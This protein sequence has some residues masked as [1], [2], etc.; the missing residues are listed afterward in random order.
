[1]P[2]TGTSGFRNAAVTKVLVTVIGSCSTL[3]SL[4]ESHLLS[5]SKQPVL[6]SISSQWVFSSIGSTVVGTWLIYK[7]RVIE[8]RYGSSKFAALV[9]ISIIVSTFFQQIA[10]TAFP[11]Q[12]SINSP[13]ALIFA[14]L[15]QYHIIIPQTNQLPFLSMTINDKTYV[16]AAAIQLFAQHVPTSVLSCVCGLLT[17]MVYNNNIGNIQK[18]R[19]PQWIRSFSS[20]YLIPLLGTTSPLHHFSSS[21]GLSS[22]SSSS[23]SS[24]TQLNN[25]YSNNHSNPL[26]QRSVPTEVPPSNENIEALISMFPHCSRE[27]VANALTSSRHDLNRAAETLLTTAPPPSESTS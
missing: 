3:A 26:R 23:A 11:G 5:T 19:F 15:Y 17:G 2:S 25:Q 22:L 13:Y 4:F 12:Y 21:T 24:T 7:L 27:V 9:F 20:T 18:W 16:Y 10:N 6:Q 1:M 8:R 14:I